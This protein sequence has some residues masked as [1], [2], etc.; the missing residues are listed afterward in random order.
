L[1]TVFDSG[2]DLDDP[3]MVDA[4]DELPLWSALA[5][6]LLFQHL[7][8]FRVR[9]ALDVGCGTGFPAIELA[10]RLRPGSTVIG[11]DTWAE[12]LHRAGRKAAARKLSNVSFVSGDAVAMPF[13][14]R[15]FD[16]IVSNL[17]VNNFD[18]PVI[19]LRECR[20]VARRGATLALT[21]NLKGHWREFYAIFE[22]SARPALRRHVDRRATI[23]QLEA[24]LTAARFGIVKVEEELVPMRFADGCALLDH[25]FV[26][27]GFFPAWRDVVAPELRE[28]TFARLERALNDAAAAQAG[29][30]L[31]VPFAYVE[32][33]A[34]DDD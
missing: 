4:Y 10:E 18:D 5:G 23:E 28:E 33:T 14:D 7:P 26:R 2:V 21:T 8:L 12:A 3:A 22:E 25:S 29:L 31:T 27:L 16:L 9:D 11:I 13:P 1:K 6:Q 34:I 19:A 17:G 20:R 15:S 32:A 30:T 24:L